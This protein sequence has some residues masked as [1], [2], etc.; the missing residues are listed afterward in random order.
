MAHRQKIGM[1]TKML[2]LMSL[3]IYV[4]TILICLSQEGKELEILF[5]SGFEMFHN[6]NSFR[7]KKKLVTP[8]LLIRRNKSP[9]N[10][11]KEKLG[12]S[13]S[14][15]PNLGPAGGLQR[16]GPQGVCKAAV[17]RFQ[18]AGAPGN[19]ESHQLSVLKISAGAQETG[20][21]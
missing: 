1:T 7:F 9:V 3:N 12:P 19:C 4:S 20:G 2:L 16:S 11:L 17:C 8:P 18:P 5:F 13:K 15:M 6:K 14:P 21:C 10:F